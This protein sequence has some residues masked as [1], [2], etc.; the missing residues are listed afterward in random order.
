MKLMVG[1]VNV[2]N[3]EEILSSSSNFSQLFASRYLRPGILSN[4]LRKP[5]AKKLVL[6]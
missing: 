1:E 2:N 6:S 4:I 5:S 3:E